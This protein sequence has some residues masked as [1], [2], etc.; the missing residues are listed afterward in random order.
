MLTVVDRD[1]MEKDMC[2]FTSESLLGDEATEKKISFF[3]SLF[4]R[5][6]VQLVVHAKKET[7]VRLLDS[8][9]SPDVKI[10]VRDETQFE[11]THE[12]A[13]VTVPKD[14]L[15]EVQF[16]LEDQLL[17]RNGDVK[18]NEEKCV[19]KHDSRVAEALDDVF[20]VD[21]LAHGHVGSCRE[22]F[23]VEKS[24]TEYWEVLVVSRVSDRFAEVFRDKDVLETLKEHFHDIHLLAHNSTDKHS[25][26]MIF[27]LTTIA[28]VED[29]LDNVNFHLPQV[30]EE[31]FPVWLIWKGQEE[32][33]EVVD[34]ISIVAVVTHKILV[35]VQLDPTNLILCEMLFVRKGVVLDKL[36]GGFTVSKETTT[37]A[38]HHVV[39]CFFSHRFLFPLLIHVTHIEECQQGDVN[40]NI[41]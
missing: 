14:T 6:L 28:V 15:R 26:E 17:V 5:F 19:E 38:L 35:V 16:F 7:T 34:V 18:T 4:D 32:E 20:V 2:V 3:S 8:D 11:E 25:V 33:C 23:S 40:E 1:L 39:H 13:H 36:L 41:I 9:G 29:D 24:H 37:A 22:L 12:E 27:T 10:G 21:N 30:A 31:L